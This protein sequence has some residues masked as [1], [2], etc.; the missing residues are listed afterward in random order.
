MPESN[1]HAAQ[2]GSERA[3]VV[4]MA[5]PRFI[6]RYAT[7]AS[8]AVLADAAKLL[9]AVS[10]TD[11]VRIVTELP[12]VIGA[13]RAWCADSGVAIVRED[14]CRVLTTIGCFTEH[15]IDL[16]RHPA[17]ECATP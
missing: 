4:T 12:A 15:I 8:D 2:C 6:C 1:A 9:Q 13:L 7:L 10:D 11:T 16:Q 5:E 14:E 3:G 17:K